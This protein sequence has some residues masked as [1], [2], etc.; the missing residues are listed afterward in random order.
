MLSATGG[1]FVFTK[2]L[3]SQASH[4]LRVSSPVIIEPNV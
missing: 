2:P 3:A 4:L 1:A